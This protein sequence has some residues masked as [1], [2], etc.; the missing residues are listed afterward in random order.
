M[1]QP[2]FGEDVR[3]LIGQRERRVEQ[4]GRRFGLRAIADG[5]P[6]EL[7]GDRKCRCQ[8]RRQRDEAQRAERVRVAKLEDDRREAENA[9]REKQAKLDAE[10]EIKRKENSGRWVDGSYKVTAWGSD[11]LFTGTY[12][13]YAV[14][15]NSNG[16]ASFHGQYLDIQNASPKYSAQYATT[17]SKGTLAP[18]EKKKIHIPFD[19]GP[20]KEIN[21]EYN[22]NVRYFVPE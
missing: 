6:T 1:T 2:V 12:Y 14:V 5:E 11:K 9:K 13:L 21:T 22:I 20:N 17:V 3:R 7:F 19:N 16:D 10:K 15:V 4:V 18:G 8:N